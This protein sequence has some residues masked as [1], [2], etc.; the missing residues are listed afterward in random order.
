MNTIFRV[1]EKNESTSEDVNLIEV[2][3]YG[4]DACS[5]ILR[6]NRG[7]KVVIKGFINTQREFIPVKL[8]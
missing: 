8:K 2:E 5:A 6:A 1:K 7:K 4:Q 3:G